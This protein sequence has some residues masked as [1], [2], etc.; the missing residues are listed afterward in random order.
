MADRVKATAHSCSIQELVYLMDAYASA[1]CYVTSAV[2]E[3]TN[4]TLLRL[5]EFTPSQ[6]CLHASSFARLDIRNDK[7]FASIAERLEQVPVGGHDISE[8]ES[9]PDHRN[10]MSARDVTLAAYSFAKLGFHQPRVFETLSRA[11]LP[12]VRDFTARDL[13]MLTVALVRAEHHDPMLLQAL[14]SQAQRRIAQFNSESMALMLRGMAFFDRRGDPLFTRALAQLPRSILTFRPGDV[15]SLLGAFAAA[16]VHSRALFDVVTPFIMEKAPMFTPTDWLLALRSYSALGHRD[17]TFLSA[18]GLHLQATK[19]SLPQIGAALT[20]CSRLSFTGASAALAEAARA[21]VAAEGSAASSAD[22]VAQMYSALLLMGVSSARPSSIVTSNV[23]EAQELLKELHEYLR[24]QNSLLALSPAVCVDLCYASLLAPPLDGI[25]R[26]PV[27]TPQLL[28]RCAQDSK[29]LTTQGRKLLG[30]VVKALELLPW[31]SAAILSAQHVG[32]VALQPC[33]QDLDSSSANSATGSQPP[34]ACLAAAAA[35][36][37]PHHHVSDIFE[38]ST[39]GDERTSFRAGIF[40]AVEIE[41]A[42]SKMGRAFRASDIEHQV[43]LHDVP[44]A[45]IFV[46]ESSK[47]PGKDVVL[48]WGSSV[49]FA[50]DLEVQPDERFWPL[51]PGAQFQK[52]SLQAKYGSS[53]EVVVLPYWLLPDMATLSGESLLDIIAEL[54]SV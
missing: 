15:T 4:Q 17:A 9:L 1:R 24:N 34:A 47:V 23:D 36:L 27:D 21:K 3:L 48:M 51:T 40:L 10:S 49:H 28:Q 31:N 25:G 11:A 38:R 39:S 43:V 5:E 19:L 32:K 12:V 37:A 50:A 33:T 26:H 18:L 2:N 16:Q 8:H 52:V 45:H 44:E 7:L 22:V 29:A 30:L 53:A 42:L 54:R 46:P 35:H 41:E 6:L 20:D 14:S 13:Q